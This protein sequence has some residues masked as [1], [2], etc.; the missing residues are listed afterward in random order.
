[1]QYTP[2]CHRYGN[3]YNYSGD[4]LPAERY[5]PCHTPVMRKANGYA[6]E[7]AAYVRRIVG[8]ALQAGKQV[9]DY[10]E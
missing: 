9:K 5:A 1:M 2:C 3:G 7:Q 8:I 10:E 6:A 4:H